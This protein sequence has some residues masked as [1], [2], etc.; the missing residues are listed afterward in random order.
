M[1][2]SD[3]YFGMENVVKNNLQDEYEVC[4]INCLCG[5]W[6]NLRAVCEYMV[7]ERMG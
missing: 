6:A 1:D 2:G 3:K 4:G 5:D 7:S